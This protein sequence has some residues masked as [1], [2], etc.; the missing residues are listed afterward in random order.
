MQKIVSTAA[1]VFMAMFAAPYSYAQDVAPD[2]LLKAATADVIAILRQDEDTQAGG[3]AKIVDLVETR[4]LQLFDFTRMAQIAV[5]R[6]WRF[7]TPAQQQ[8]LISEFKVL[9]L[10]TY[11]SSL[12]NY[13]DRIIEFKPLRAVLDDT[14]VTVKSLVKQSGVSPITMNFDMEKVVT[15]WKVYDIKIDGRSLIS[16]YR[17]TFARIVR[18][19]GLEGLIQ[20]ISAQNLQGE[21]RLRSP[22]KEDY[23]F[24]IVVWGMLQRGR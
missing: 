6:N 22:Q 3:P 7:A 8:V 21:A 14:E 13:R 24:P 15:G 1:L 20:S 5:A 19:G 11:T 18:D 10:R 12:S 16:A 2:A 9:L 23:Y 4:V 17:E